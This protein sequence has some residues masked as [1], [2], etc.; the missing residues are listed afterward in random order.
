MSACWVASGLVGPAVNT[1]KS[2]MT[3]SSLKGDTGSDRDI[4]GLRFRVDIAIPE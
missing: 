1:K 2:C 3:L 4:W